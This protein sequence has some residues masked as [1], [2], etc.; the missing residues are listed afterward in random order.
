M[1]KPRVMTIVE[2]LLNNDFQ[3]I[4]A[5]NPIN[6]NKN[7]IKDIPN[8]I[9]SGCICNK[10]ATKRTILP[11][12]TVIK[13]NAMQTKENIN[14]KRLIFIFIVPLLNYSKALFDR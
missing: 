10:L 4:D 9:S 11:D 14:A 3:F 12:N 7:V 1:H 6:P 5:E 13:N 2:I 8:T